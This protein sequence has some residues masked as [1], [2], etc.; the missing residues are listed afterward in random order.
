MDSW[1][2]TGVYESYTDSEGNFSIVIPYFSKYYIQIVDEE[3]HAHKASLELQK[4]RAETNV[5]EI[6][7][8][9]DIFKQNPDK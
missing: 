3:G 8:V 4:Y 2:G 5:H 1:L 7:I 6:V 9:K